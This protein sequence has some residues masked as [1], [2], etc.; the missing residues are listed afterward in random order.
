MSYINDKI[1]YKHS[2]ATISFH[3]F[4]SQIK[5]KQVVWQKKGQSGRPLAHF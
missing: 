2:I 4:S 5:N 1:D 3:D